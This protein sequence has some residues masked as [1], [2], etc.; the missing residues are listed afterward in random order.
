MDAEQSAAAL[1]SSTQQ[2]H[3]ALG[4]RV[5]L[6]GV[7][8]ESVE[9]SPSR[10]PVLEHRRQSSR[11]AVI[12][13][14]ASSESGLEHY[15][16]SVLATHVAVPPSPSLEPPH[17]STSRT[18]HALAQSTRCVSVFKST[19]QYEASRRRGP[20]QQI[21]SG[22]GNMYRWLL[23]MRFSGQER[24]VAGAAHQGRA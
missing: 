13:P 12:V 17:V 19:I 23:A 22:V 18:M 9:R 8:S 15:T 16:V 10:V 2:Q 3:S 4:L 14:S 21:S 7:I 6:T 11:S 5:I 1:S 24:A 20:A